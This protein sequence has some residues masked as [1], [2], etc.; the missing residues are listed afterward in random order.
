[1]SQ[2]P[3]KISDFTLVDFKFCHTVSSFTLN[4]L[5]RDLFSYTLDTSP[6]VT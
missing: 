1:M 6:P 5:Q 4:V 2:S 3:T